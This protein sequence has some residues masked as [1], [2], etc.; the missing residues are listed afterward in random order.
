MNTNILLRGGDFDVCFHSEAFVKLVI[1][2]A[3]VDTESLKEFSVNDSDAFKRAWYPNVRAIEALNYDSDLC[4]EFTTNANDPS[5]DVW[6]KLTLEAGFITLGSVKEPGLPGDLEL[7]FTGESEDIPTIIEEL[8]VH[9]YPMMDH[10]P[11]IAIVEDSLHV[12][13]D[14]VRVV[15]AVK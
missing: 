5:Q 3:A 8:E 2:F 10:A 6:L 14:L 13:G 11:E 7:C 1:L 12:V 4:N 15:L 9:L